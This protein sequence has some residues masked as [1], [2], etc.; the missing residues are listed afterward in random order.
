MKTP[1]QYNPHSQLVGP[2]CPSATKL[3]FLAAPMLLCGTF[4]AS[5]SNVALKANDALNSSSITGSKNGLANNVFV[6]D[7]L[8]L[9]T[10]LN[11]D[12]D[13]V[14]LKE[15]QSSVQCLLM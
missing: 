14:T 12:S 13:S 1:N 9:C 11:G 7:A 15:D 6:G 2:Q 10:N 8:V 5:A 3:H 4:F